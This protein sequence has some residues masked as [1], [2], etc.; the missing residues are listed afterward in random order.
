MRERA[1]PQRVTNVELFFD[2]VFVFA[3]TQLSHFLLAGPRAGGAVRTTL[4]AALLLI[5][6]WQLWVYT[7]WV[8]NWLDPDRIA[9]RSLLLALAVISLLMSAAIPTAFGRSGLIIGASYLVMQVGRSVFTVRA[10]GDRGLRRNFER[11]LAWCSVSGLLAL[12]GGLAHGD[13]RLLLWAGAV[14]IDLTGGAVGFSTPWLGKSSTADWTIEG[15]HF[16]ERCQGFILIAI[17][18]SIVVIGAT[19]AARLGSP[20]RLSGAEI[21]A[22]LIAVASSVAFWWLYFDRSAKDATE[23]IAHSADPGRL[24]RS[25]YHFIHPVMV[26]GI[27]VTA[28]ADGATAE[29]AGAGAGAGPVSSWVAWLVLAGPALF[30]A[31]HAAFKAAVWRRVS[32]SRVAAVCVLALLGLLAPHVPAVVLS[33]CAAAVVIAVVIADQL[34]PPAADEESEATGAAGAAEPSSGG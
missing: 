34:W 6:V 24:G 3:V 15:G 12:G 9:V 30:L 10:I 4:E 13:A 21:A 22:F 25:A 20:L 32:W 18:E 31:G 8:T 19:L 33:G 23:I 1:G 28:A 27:I 14:A 16:A 17:G 29:A 7:T 2:L 5:M 26:A 11:I